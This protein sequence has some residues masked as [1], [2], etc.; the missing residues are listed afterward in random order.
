MGKMESPFKDPRIRA[1]LALA[2]VLVGAAYLALKDHILFSKRRFGEPAPALVADI[3]GALYVVAAV[4]ALW[5]A[6]RLHRLN[7]SARKSIG[8]SDDNPPSPSGD[9]PQ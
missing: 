1:C 7:A 3:F 5:Y 4:A 9:L 2:A 6:Q 8:E